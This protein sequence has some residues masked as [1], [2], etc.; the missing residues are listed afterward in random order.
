MECVNYKP[1]TIDF[2]IP[3]LSEAKTLCTS[4]DKTY[5]VIIIIIRLA[6]ITTLLCW[7]Y[8]TFKNNFAFIVVVLLAV[9]LY[10]NSLLLILAIITKQAYKKK[11]VK[12][13]VQKKIFVPQLWYNSLLDRPKTACPIGY[14]ETR[15]LN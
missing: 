5:M 10:M 9:Y 7:L 13:Q 12:V 6:V 15:S 11:L 8:F 2:L 14:I 3:S 4:Y 1:S